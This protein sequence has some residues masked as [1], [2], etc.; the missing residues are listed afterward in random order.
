VF[1]FCYPQLV[2][3]YFEKEKM[4]LQGEPDRMT[5]QC[6]QWYMVN[7]YTILALFA[8]LIP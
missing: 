3:Q 1:P 8:I 6:M 7:V 5:D 4:G 2:G